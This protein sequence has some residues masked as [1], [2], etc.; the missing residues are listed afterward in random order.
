[1]S[2]NI[3]LAQATGET[4]GSPVNFEKLFNVQPS[5]HL[6]GFSEVESPD[7]IKE[8]FL[9]PYKNS[10]KSESLVSI[11]SGMLVNKVEQSPRSVSGRSN[12]QFNIFKPQGMMPTFQSKR[13]LS[14]CVPTQLQ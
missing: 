2:D 7:V 9:R 10:D 3:R 12:S 5:K 1:L 14:V 6:E 4:P 11:R 8:A 13:N